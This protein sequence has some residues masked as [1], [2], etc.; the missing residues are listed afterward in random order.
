[1]GESLGSFKVVS[2]YDNLTTLIGQIRVPH[3]AVIKQ[4]IETE[5]RKQISL[6]NSK[7]KL[8]GFVTIK[9]IVQEDDND[10]GEMTQLFTPNEFRY[11]NSDM[12]NL[13]NTHILSNFTNDVA[14][15]FTIHLKETKK[16]LTID[17]LELK[18]RY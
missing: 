8:T 14:T 15:Q 10:D 13:T 16:V 18:V 1:M 3:L 6:N 2:F 17:L 9:Y 7:H 4:Y 5:L 11:F 12:V